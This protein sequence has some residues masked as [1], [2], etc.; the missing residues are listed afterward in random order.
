MSTLRVD[1]I[2]PYLSSSIDIVGFTQAVGGAT[3]GSNVFVGN[4]T[5]TGSIDIT[6]EF[7]VNGSP[8]TGSGGSVDTSSLATTG[9]NQFN[10]NQQ[11]TGSLLVSEAVSS[12]I[13]FSGDGSGLSNVNATSLG[14]LVA[15]R[16]AT[17]GS[18]TFSGTQAIVSASVF[19]VNISP[20]AIAN[21]DGSGGTGQTKLIA[22]SA[23][24]KNQG[25]AFT[26]WNPQPTLYGIGSSGPYQIAEFQSQGNFT[27]GTVT[28]KR[29][30]IVSGSIIATG[31]ISAPNLTGSAAINTGSF[32]TTG[33]NSFDGNQS[34]T[35][36][37]EV[38]GSSTFRGDTV[39]ASIDTLPAGTPG[40][41]AFQGGNMHVYI[42][43]QWNQVQFVS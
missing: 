12:S 41:I 24:P 37:F 23:N 4:Q 18:N 30:I 2:E 36:S 17:T 3:T 9:S 1:K 14:G 6:G 28:F 29:P 5:V 16:Y 43:G 42:S 7:L 34:V 20:V 31:N 22:L 38:T 25:G 19:N 39:I 27:D 40:Q 26:S 32:A 10:G 15:A 35:G 33:S 21:S 13:G 8:I 11:I